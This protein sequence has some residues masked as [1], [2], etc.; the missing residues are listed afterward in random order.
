MVNQDELEGAND[1]SPTKKLEAKNKLTP[2]VL[3][4]VDKNRGLCY[5]DHQTK[6]SFWH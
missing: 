4:L 6:G 5:L 1:T 3:V 2:G